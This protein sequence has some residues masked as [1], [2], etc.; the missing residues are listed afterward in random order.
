MEPL[1]LLAAAPGT[2]VIGGRSFTIPPITLADKFRVAE[3]MQ[4]LAQVKCLSPVDYAA[5]HTHLPP[6]VFA[7]MMSEALKLGSGSGQAGGVKPTTEAVWDE[8][9][10]LDGIRYRVWYH[11]SRGL[12]AFTPEEAAA[13]VTADNR[14][15]ASD[16]LDKALKLDRIDPKGQANGTGSPG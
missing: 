16:A 13:L 7:V 8:Y 12:P 4:E 14:F 10:T 9:A 1:V 6:A 2:L 15:D 5:Q 11:V 3:R